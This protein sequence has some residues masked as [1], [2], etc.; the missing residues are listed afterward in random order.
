MAAGFGVTLVTGAQAQVRIPGLVFRPIAEENAH[1]EVELVWV[2][3]KED[4]VVGRFVSF[5]KKIAR[6]RELV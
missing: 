4:S 3:E 2:A 6:T 1:L 5:M